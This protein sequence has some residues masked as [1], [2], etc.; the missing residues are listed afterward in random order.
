MIAA[1]VDCFHN[2]H[3]KVIFRDHDLSFW[4]THFFSFCSFFP[5]PHAEF[6]FD[7]L[8]IFDTTN[9]PA[10]SGNAGRELKRWLKV[11]DSSKPCLYAPENMSFFIASKAFFNKQNINLK[12]GIF[13][14]LRASKKASPLE[15]KYSIPVYCPETEPR[16]IE[17]AV[18]DLQIRYLHKNSVR[19]EDY[20]HFF[21]A[22]LVPIGKNTR[23]GS[24]VV[25]KG[26]SRIGKNVQ[27]YQNSFILPDPAWVYHPRFNN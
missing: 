24:G 12:P 13:K 26:E 16:K 27:I 7:F 19:I 10:C 3:N 15:L 8:F 2:K 18:I 20:G 22:G 6:N 21:L 23:L 11:Q 17:S 9:F 4:L 5:L 14:W 25:I 1:V